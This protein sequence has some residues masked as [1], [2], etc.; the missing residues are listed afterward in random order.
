LA[1]SVAGVQVTF[2]GV[3]V[4]LLAVSAQQIELMTPF[5]LTGKLT[6]TIQVQYNGVKSNAVQVPVAA[7]EVQILGV[8]N[9]DFTPN[10]AANPAAPG[11]EMCLY[12]GGVGNANPPSQD[13]HVNG[14]PFE[15]LALPVQVLWFVPQTGGADTLPLFFAGSAPG[16][17]AGIFQI[18][19]AAPSASGGAELAQVLGPN[20]FGASGSFQIYIKQ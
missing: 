18:N 19:F 14:P 4:P 10:S 6:T 5:E 11:S 16:T 9:D 1:T 17:V 13:G 8:F 2:D 3:T 7:I 15:P 12:A 20:E